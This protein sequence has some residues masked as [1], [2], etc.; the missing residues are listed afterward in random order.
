MAFSYQTLKRITG[1][2]IVDDTLTGAD[3]ADGLVSNQKIVGAN[4]TSA[5]ID[6]NAVNMG[7]N[8]VT[9]T[10]PTSKGGTGRTTVGSANQLFTVNS[11][12]NG[13]TF[14]NHGI[15]GM[16]V[17]TGGGTWS[18]PSG[19][20]YVKVQVQGAGG[21]GS[22]HGESGGSGGYSERIIDVTGVNSVSIGVGGA[23]S[24]TYYS[25]AGGNSSGSSFGNYCSASGG[26]GA[27]RNN[28]HSGG[29]GGV[30]SGGTL[31]IY[32]GGGQPHHTRSSVGGQNFWGGAVAAGHPQGGH[33]SHRHE[34]HAS[35][36]AG[37]SGGYFTGHRGANGRNGMVVVVMYY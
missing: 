35:P 6:T 15:Y 36:G 9:G 30:G 24:G 29:L 4:V 11:S 12:G 26:Y 37:G 19:V 1:T 28:Q 34:S 18:K 22:G 17:Y 2:A 13:T 16:S 14:S 23:G 25:G 32:G 27:N 10:T 21:G 7:S 5:K 20:R 31:N 8:V 33:F 3:L